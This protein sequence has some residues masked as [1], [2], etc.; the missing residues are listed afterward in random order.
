MLGTMDVHHQWTK[1]MRPQSPCLLR[2]FPPVLLT[3]P[4]P[5]PPQL[6]E[7]LPGYRSLQQQTDWLKE[8]ISL[9]LGGTQVVHVE[10]LR[11]VQSIGEHYGSLS[12]FHKSLVSRRLRL[13]PRSLQGLTML[14]E[15]Y[16]VPRQPELLERT[17]L[18]SCLVHRNT[19][20]HKDDI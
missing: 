14:L 18:T 20:T 4:L 6:F 16:A 15:K 12:A 3:R 2:L 19:H 1:V 7:Q 9:L 10:R 11:P 13:H 5:V 17:T 8:R